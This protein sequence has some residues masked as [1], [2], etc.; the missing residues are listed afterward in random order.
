MRFVKLMLFKLTSALSSVN[1]NEGLILITVRKDM[2]IKEKNK[3]QTKQAQYV[4]ECCGAT[5]DQL[6]EC[7]GEAMKKED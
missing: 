3:K 7:C 4:C 6:G 2:K 1:T 5:S